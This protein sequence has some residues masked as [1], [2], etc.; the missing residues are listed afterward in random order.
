MNVYGLIGYPLSHSFSPDY[1]A[2]K[3]E[4]LNI[5]DSSYQSFPIPNIEEL[6]KLLT[7]NNSIK[8]LNVTIPYKTSVM[9][10]LDKVDLAAKEIGAVN[11]IKIDNNKRLIGYNT[12][13]YGFERSL[14]PLLTKPIKALVLGTGGA[15]K[16]VTYVLKKLNIEFILISRN[17]SKGITYNNLSEEIISSHL[18]IINTTPI[19]MYPNDDSKPDIPYHLLTNDHILYDLVYNPEETL[20]LKAGKEKGATIKNGLEMLHLQADKSWDIWQNN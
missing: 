2:K 18:L 4:L 7:D 1:F 19:G 9:D 10:Y 14:T 20:F 6:S 13:V 16:A 8:G 11:T 5:K 15:A 12:D 17:N 3:F